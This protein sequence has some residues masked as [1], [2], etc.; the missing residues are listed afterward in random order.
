MSNKIKTALVTGAS[1]GIGLELTKKLL[2]EDITVIAVTRSGEI[3]GLSHP[4]L[5]VFKGDISSEESISKVAQQVEEAGISI[6]CLINNA[7]VGVDFTTEIPTAAALNESFATNTT[8]TALFTEALLSKVTD[9]GQIIFLST[10]MSLLRAAAP[11]APAYRMSKAALNMYVVMLSERLV[12]RNIRVTAVHPGWVQTRMG[13]ESAPTTIEQSV[14]G[15]YKAI[16]ENTG[17][18]KFWNVDAAGIE[19]Y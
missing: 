18:G 15:I 9:G 5:T 6:D 1:N 12:K 7:G 10:I 14:N 2:N 11:D 19:N 16:T 3:A 4:N 17:T 13:G 8:G